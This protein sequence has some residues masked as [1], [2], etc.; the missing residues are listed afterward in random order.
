[1]L[2]RTVDVTANKDTCLSK[3]HSIYHIWRYCCCGSILHSVRFKKTSIRLFPEGDRFVNRG[4]T[5]INFVEH[6]W[7]RK[8][9]PCFINL[10]KHEWKFGRTRNVVGTRAAGECFHSFFEFS[11]TFIQ[12]LNPLHRRFVNTKKQSPAHDA[13][14]LTIYHRIFNVSSVAN[15]SMALVIEW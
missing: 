4:L 6:L 15:Q 12:I 2:W 8:P 13:T 7:N 5:V 3:K 9:V 1:M 10:Q 11:Q 14:L